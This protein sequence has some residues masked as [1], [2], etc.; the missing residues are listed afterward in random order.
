MLKGRKKERRKKKGFMENISLPPLSLSLSLPRLMPGLNPFTITFNHYLSF[1][2]LQ[3]CCLN[4]G[5]ATSP[6]RSAPAPNCSPSA[7]I[8]TPLGFKGAAGEKGGGPGGTVAFTSVQICED[9]VIYSSARAVYQFIQKNLPLPF[10]NR[11]SRSTP[12]GTCSAGERCDP[13]LLC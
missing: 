1:Y 4:R 2:L 10:T 3:P 6:I 7:L 9:N 13:I 5:G 8:S 12:D 11:Y